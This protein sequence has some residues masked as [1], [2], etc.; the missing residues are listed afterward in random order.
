MDASPIGG[1]IT[2]AVYLESQKA[3]KDLKVGGGRLLGCPLGAPWDLKKTRG[4]PT[5][6]ELQKEREREREARTCHR[7]TSTSNSDDKF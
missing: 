4:S 2:W 7:E 6:A 5:G 3:K 1:T